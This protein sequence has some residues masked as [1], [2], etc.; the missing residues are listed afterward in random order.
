VTP[1]TR[2]ELFEMMQ[3]KGFRL[4][5]EL[6]EEKKAIQTIDDVEKRQEALKLLEQQEKQLLLGLP[7]VQ[8]LAVQYNPNPLS[9]FRDVVDEVVSTL[10]AVI[11]GA[12]NPKWIAGPLGIVQVMQ[13]QWMVSLKEALFWLGII[14]LNLGLLNLL[15]L[16][17]LDGG[18][19]ALS[20]FEMASGRRLKAKTI[21]KIVVPF[22]ILLI[23]FF[24]FLTYNDIVRIVSN[25]FHL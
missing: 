3:D 20:L 10:S 22:A 25:L 5:S 1:K 19:V 18:Y 9:M 15:P 4:A 23:T 12:L 17:I 2:L 13:H 24:V 16:P 6:A 8:D 21:E 7:G 14:S 11:G